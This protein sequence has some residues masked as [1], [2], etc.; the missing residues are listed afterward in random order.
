MST[1]HRLALQAKSVQ[2]LAELAPVEKIKKLQEPLW[3]E[4]A[5]IQAKLCDPITASATDVGMIAYI[6]V[7]A[8]DKNLRDQCLRI[9]ARWKAAPPQI[10]PNVS[11]W[12]ILGIPATNNKAEIEK[13]YKHRALG[14]HPDRHA[15]CSRDH[16]QKWT[17]AFQRLGRA[18]K[19]ALEKGH[20]SN[21]GGL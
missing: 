11:C 21:G 5:R 7:Q 15:G 4:V 6:A 13:A 18:K 17:A 9:L 19:E 20:L 10:G 14:W 3:F 1:A 12:T 16:R 8:A 2:D